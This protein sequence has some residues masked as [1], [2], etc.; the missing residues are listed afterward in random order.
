M[1]F[2]E[3]LP[4]CSEIIK[5]IK[6]KDPG[7]VEYFRRYPN[8]FLIFLYPL[9]NSVLCQYNHRKNKKEKKNG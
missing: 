9:D 4:E 7:F 3:S 8:Y 2:P 5:I 1:L 6:E